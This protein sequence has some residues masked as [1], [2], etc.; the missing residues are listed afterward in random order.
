MDLDIVREAVVEYCENIYALGVGFLNKH[1]NT[2]LKEVLDKIIILNNNIRNCKDV[3]E[4]FNYK[5]E[6]LQL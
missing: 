3:N 2:E 5:H 6:V 1:N 4:I